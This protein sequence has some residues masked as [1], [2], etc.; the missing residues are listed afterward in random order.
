MGFAGM[1]PEFIG[2]GEGIGKGSLGNLMSPRNILL[3][4]NG[5]FGRMCRR[6]LYMK[7]MYVVSVILRKEKKWRIKMG[8]GE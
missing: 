2:F 5:I 1:N 7:R 3:R 4:A 8:W 6:N